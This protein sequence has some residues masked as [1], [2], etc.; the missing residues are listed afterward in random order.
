M[1]QR[2]IAAVRDMPLS[3]MGPN[4][5]SYDAH[6]AVGD[7]A[8]DPFLVVSLFDMIG[9]T[10][11]PHPHAGFTVVTYMLPE[12]PVSF[13]N[14]DSLGLRN[15][16]LPGG[17]HATI[18]GAGVLHEEQPIRTGG[19]AKGYQIWIDHR[20]GERSVPARAVSLEAADVPV[21][22]DEGVTLRVL[23]G[24]A[25]GMTS[26]VR[27]PTPVRLLDVALAPGAT[28]TESIAADEQGYLVVVDGAFTADGQLV[29]RGQVAT[30]GPTGD[31][32]SITAG[33]DG[34]RVTYFLGAPL[35]QPRVFAGPVVGGSK[36]EALAFLKAAS[37][38]A[39]GSLRAFD[40]Q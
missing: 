31:A 20:N 7:T 40:E 8:S 30:L 32:L 21:W 35:R 18:A 28:L 12:S 22:R 25:Q 11:P 5:R 19:L 13:I 26:P 38:G 23:L 17:L 2:R 34:A 27:L 39:F 24:A 15:E 33:A 9:P 29:T 14:Q 10:F 36:A 6:T 4:L 16:I 3:Q 37:A 1:T